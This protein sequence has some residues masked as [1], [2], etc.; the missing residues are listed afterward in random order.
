MTM[1]DNTVKTIAKGAVEQAKDIVKDTLSESTQR[2]P[3]PKQSG[4]MRRWFVLVGLAAAVGLGIW[5]LRRR[6]QGGG[7]YEGETAPDA[8]GA[9]VDEERR[10][11]AFGDRPV[12][13]PGA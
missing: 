2:S 9:A 5:F 4:G 6:A 13:T 7:G 8:F 11:Q 3:E 1:I 12:A 10:M